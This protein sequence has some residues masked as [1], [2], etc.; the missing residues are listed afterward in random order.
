MK[1]TP[2]RVVFCF[3]NTDGELGYKAVVVVQPIQDGNCQ[4]PPLGGQSFH[5]LEMTNQNSRSL[6]FN[7]AFLALRL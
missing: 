1:Q 6:F 3:R 4:Q 5:T 7:L 2:P